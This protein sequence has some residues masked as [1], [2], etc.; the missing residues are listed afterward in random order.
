MLTEVNRANGMKV[1]KRHYDGK[2]YDY[3]IHDL[4][5]TKNPLRATFITKAEADKHIGHVPV[6]PVIETKPAKEYKTNPH[7]KSG[8]GKGK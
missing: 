8:K 6:A 4:D 5:D 2:V 7:V 1:M 3:Q